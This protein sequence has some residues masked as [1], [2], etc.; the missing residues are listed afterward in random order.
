[1][2]SGSRADKR[3]SFRASAFPSL[4]SC[5][6]AMGRRARL[7]P[8]PPPAAKSRQRLGTGS[9]GAGSRQRL[10]RRRRL[11]A[12][13]A[14]PNLSTHPLP[15]RRPR[16]LSPESPS[17]V[18]AERCA[19]GAIGR[20]PHPVAPLPASRPHLEPPAA[21][22]RPGALPDVGLRHW[23]RSPSPRRAPPG[24]RGR[25]G[26][27]RRAPG[28]PSCRRPFVRAGALTACAD[29]SAAAAAAARPAA[30]AAGPRTWPGA[31]GRRCGGGLAP[32]RPGAS[33]PGGP[34]SPQA[35][36]C[37]A[38]AGPPTAP[39][40]RG[41]ARGAGRPQGAP[42]PARRRGP[43]PGPGKGWKMQAGAEGW[44]RWDG[45]GDAGKGRGVLRGRGYLEEGRRGGGR[46][47]GDGLWRNPGVMGI[48]KG[49]RGWEGDVVRG[50]GEAHILPTVSSSCPGPGVLYPV[51][52]RWAWLDYTAP[53]S[54]FSNC[55][56]WGCQSS[57]SLALSHQV[58][59]CC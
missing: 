3:A 27:G 15:T 52:A 1:M 38:G 53:C 47:G 20:V 18:P 11:L 41:G 31:R 8:P 55:S 46:R 54:P 51:W 44:T 48:G 17:Q 26:S 5:I 37:G 33:R 7:H 9:S 24:E 42:P 10:K 16:A 21:A 43:L 45:R 56:E 58:L 19:P 25:R 40:S 2:E 29:G 59:H 49:V 39:G 4:N 28:R 6:C 23:P 50:V 22:A 13:A 36:R 35:G 34:P 12:P 32:G 57:S 14:A 30:R